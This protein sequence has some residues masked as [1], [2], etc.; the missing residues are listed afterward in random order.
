MHQNVLLVVVL[1]LVAGCQT[2]KVVGHTNGMEV[3]K[4]ERTIQYDSTKN[5]TNVFIN[6][7]LC[8]KAKHR[9][10]AKVPILFE[11]TPVVV[12][13]VTTQ[14]ET[15]VLEAFTLK[16]WPEGLPTKSLDSCQTVF[17]DNPPDGM[18]IHAR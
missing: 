9:F 16:A 18:V 10:L 7:I 8:E 14:G 6:G 15:V 5:L 11:S 13:T 4:G 2:G 12:T 1:V 3:A 17:I